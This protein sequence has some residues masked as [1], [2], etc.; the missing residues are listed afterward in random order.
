MVYGP[1]TGFPDDCEYEYTCGPAAYR[2]SLALP[3]VRNNACY[4]PPHVRK[5][6]PVA[7]WLSSKL[8]METVERQ[9]RAGREGK[10][11]R[12]NSNKRRK[13]GHEQGDGGHPSDG[14]SRQGQQ[15]GGM[16]SAGDKAVA[17]G[18][19]AKERGGGG[20]AVPGKKRPR[21]DAS[22]A[23]GMSKH[24]FPT[25]YS[26][27][28]ETP[29]QA[30]RDIEGPLALLSKLLG[31]KRKHLQIWDPYVS[32][33]DKLPPRTTQKRSASRRRHGIHLRQALLLVLSIPVVSVAAEYGPR[34]V[35]RC[36]TW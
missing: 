22:A 10:A 21:E 1:S 27:H 12:K 32:P 17:Q 2:C 14:H 9:T 33:R 8:D 20:G 36:E 29:L 7:G 26:D 31:K 18:G 3:R 4:L 6:N 28:F 5:R 23:Q 16:D 11:Q 35:Q 13:A 34:T 24:P 15:R 25:E 30:Y 19:G